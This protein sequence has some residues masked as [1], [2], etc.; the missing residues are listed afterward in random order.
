MAS[1]AHGE[2]ITGSSLTGHGKPILNQKKNTESEI[3]PNQPITSLAPGITSRRRW[4]AERSIPIQK[5]TKQAN[6]ELS[7]PNTEHRGVYQK[8]KKKKPP[9]HKPKSNPLNHLPTDGHVAAVVDATRSSSFAWSLLIVDRRS[10]NGERRSVLGV[11]RSVKV[12]RSF[13]S[14]ILSQSLAL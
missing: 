2:P 13:F 3:E 7:K 11:R 8:K 10:E 4:L 14:L 5:Q 6:T 12:F 9:I 1:Q